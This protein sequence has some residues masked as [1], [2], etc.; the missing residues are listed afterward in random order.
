LAVNTFSKAENHAKAFC[1]AL[2]HCLIAGVVI[3]AVGLAGD[4]GE[5]PCE[6]VLGDGVSLGVAL[7]LAASKPKIGN[8]QSSC[9]LDG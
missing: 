9:R 7:F 3:A 4:F 6:D 8:C 5:P 1:S 2:R